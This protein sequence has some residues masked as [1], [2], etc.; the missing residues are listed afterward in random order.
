M[1]G[2]STESQSTATFTEESSILQE[3]V[4]PMCTIKPVELSQDMLRAAQKCCGDY[5][6]GGVGSQAQLFL[7][8]YGTH[9]FPDEQTFGGIYSKSVTAEFSQ[10]VSSFDAS[11]ALTANYSQS[12]AAGGLIEEAIL[13]GGASLSFSASV[14]GSR[15]GTQ[16]TVNSTVQAQTL[17]FGPAAKDPEQFASAME[18]P[19]NFTLID[20]GICTPVWDHPALLTLSNCT[21]NLKR[22]FVDLLRAGYDH[23]PPT[24][25]AEFLKAAGEFCGDYV[26]Q[27]R[28]ANAKRIKSLFFA[29]PKPIQFAFEQ[30]RPS[31]VPHWD[32]VPR[33]TQEGDTRVYIMGDERSFNDP[34]YLPTQTKQTIGVRQPSAHVNLVAR[35][36]H[37]ICAVQIVQGGRG[38]LSGYAPW[39]DPSTEFS[40]T[41]NQEI[42]DGDGFCLNWYFN[43][44]ECLLVTDLYLPCL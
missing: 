20:R 27:I 31:E 5:F 28:A 12:L 37:V 34:A 9:V 25:Q 18:D 14:A 6:T 21:N 8:L 44:T 11:S 10:R 7:K 13:H 24:V 35:P 4:V 1:A 32:P 29:M 43:Y 22:A 19:R 41:I 26:A 17:V 36:G 15:S 3:I 40:M 38:S 39:L 2:N 23:L 16:T 30:A 33:V 42:G